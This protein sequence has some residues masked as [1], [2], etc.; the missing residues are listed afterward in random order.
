LASTLGVTTKF[1]GMNT[2]AAGE[3]PGG[4]TDAPRQMFVGLV[5]MRLHAKG[6][7]AEELKKNIAE[8]DKQVKMASEYGATFCVQ[9]SDKKDLHARN[10]ARVCAAFQGAG[11]SLGSDERTELQHEPGRVCNHAQAGVAS[12]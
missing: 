12:D 10:G 4:W 11:Q 8:L 2:L 7:N 9:F 1:S 5:N 6:G 3:S